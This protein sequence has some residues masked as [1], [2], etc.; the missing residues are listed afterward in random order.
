[1][2]SYIIKC[3][4]LQHRK[5]VEDYIKRKLN[6]SEVIHHIDRNR[7]NNKINNL[8]IFKTQREHMSF[9]RKIDQFGMT[10][11]IKRQIKNRWK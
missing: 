2:N 5:V 4:V 3:N 9:H 8:M 11:P 7:Q 1:M 10:N 6:K